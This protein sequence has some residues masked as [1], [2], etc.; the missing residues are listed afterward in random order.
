MSA[1]PQT[2]TG[3]E[4]PAM[5]TRSNKQFV[6]LSAIAMLLVVMGHVNEPLLTFGGLLPYYSFHIALFLFVSGYF[7]KEEAQEKPGKYILKK[8]KHLLLPYFLWNLFYGI[9]VV[10]LRQCGF[11]IGNEPSVWTLL[12]EPFYRDISFPIMHRHGLFRRC[13]WC[14]LP[15]W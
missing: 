5:H 7:Y 13:F 12:V 11:F 10:L 2:N 3:K 1:Q 4:N 6:L 8:A 14:R 9:A 15:M